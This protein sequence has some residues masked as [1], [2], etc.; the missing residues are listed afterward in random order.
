MLAVSEIT[1]CTRRPLHA[2]GLRAWKYHIK[3]GTVLGH[4]VV[5]FSL[6]GCFSPGHPCTRAVPSCRKHY[7]RPAQQC[8]AKLR[9]YHG[10]AVHRT[11]GR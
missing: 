10:L 1:V 2:V 4:V 8:V 11:N 3:Y 7:N 9:G 5:H 6:E